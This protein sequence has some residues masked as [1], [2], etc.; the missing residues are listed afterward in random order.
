[1]P[2]KGSLNHS[3][4]SS[5]TAVRAD[6]LHRARC[7][8]ACGPA[9][10]L[11][12]QRPVAS[13]PAMPPRSAT[14]GARRPADAVTESVLRI[15]QDARAAEARF[16]GG[17]VHAV[18]SDA[19]DAAEAGMLAALEAAG[20]GAELSAAALDA[21]EG[22]LSEPRT[23]VR[24]AAAITV[25]VAAGTSERC[26]SQVAAPG[27]ASWEAGARSFAGRFCSGRSRAHCPPAHLSPTH[28]PP[29]SPRSSGGR[30]LS[31]AWWTRGTARRTTG[32]PKS[33][34][35]GR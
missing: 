34:S 10:K 21:L 31:R 30:P 18:P 3:F 2:F 25:D 9:S 13:A 6:T 23:L 8:A 22:A 19:L 27:R 35:R 7:T 29:L 20:V 32:S 24:S 11:S 16:V 5:V 26:A 33:A 1:M 12:A 4:N 28:P 15:L 17:A 14:R